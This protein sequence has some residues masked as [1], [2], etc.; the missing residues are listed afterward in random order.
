MFRVV[1]LFFELLFSSDNAF[2]Q[3]ENKDQ[4]LADAESIFS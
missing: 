4:N 1:G 3:E 2:A